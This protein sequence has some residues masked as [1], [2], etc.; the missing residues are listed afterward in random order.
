[1]RNKAKTPFKKIPPRAGSLVTWNG[2]PA[3]RHSR[4]RTSFGAVQSGVLET[5]DL[6]W[7]APYTIVTASLMALEPMTLALATSKIFKC[8][9]FKPCSVQVR[10]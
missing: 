6:T 10:G 9:L 1:M 3:R 2:H 4:W 7:G 8:E 5:S